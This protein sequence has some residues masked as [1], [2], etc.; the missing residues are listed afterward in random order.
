LLEDENIKYLAESGCDTV[1][2]GAESGSQ[3]ILDAMD[4]G[5]TVEE[6][7]KAVLL[8]KKHK[9][10][11]ALF[12]QFGYLNEDAADIKQTIDI[13]NELLPHDIG[14]SVSYPL[15]GTKFY[16]KV[17]EQLKTKTNW[18]DSDDLHL[19]FKNTYSAEFYKSLHRYVH[20][21]YR[22]N[23]ARAHFMQFSFSHYKQIGLWPYYKLKSIKEKST[24]KKIEPLASSFL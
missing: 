23:Q 22:A 18:T 6:I 8:L 16:D 15:P 21:T 11:P 10:K 12:L 5:I 2:M 20:N 9:I 24:L 7:R 4:K 13:V 1:W 3:K 17:K 14:I 19:M